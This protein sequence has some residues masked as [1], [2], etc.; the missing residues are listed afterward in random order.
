MLIVIKNDSVHILFLVVLL[1]F[2]ILIGCSNGNT[3]AT[4]NT[5]YTSRQD[6]DMMNS[7][8][9]ND[10]EIKVMEY[11]PDDN[12]VKL[13]IKNNSSSDLQFGVWFS[14]K[15]TEEYTMR[16]GF[17]FRDLEYILHPG[18]STEKVYNIGVYADKLETGDYEFT[19]RN[20]NLVGDDETIQYELYYE[21]KQKNVFD[22]VIPFTVP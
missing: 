20:M 18:E 6:A 11:L 17:A 4:D 9:D 15:G 19:L 22:A 14:L 7:W 12:V 16:K 8:N 5:V 1:V 13:S 2:L 21:T 10:I 3:S